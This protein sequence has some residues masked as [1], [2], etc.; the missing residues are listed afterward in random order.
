LAGAKVRDPFEGE[1]LV[2]KVDQDGAA[3]N[4]IKAAEFLRSG[5]VD[6]HRDPLDLGAQCLLGDREPYAPWLRA[7]FRGSAAWRVV[8]LSLIVQV[9]GDNL[10]PALLHLEGPETVPGPH[11]E[12]AHPGHVRRKAV[13]IDVRT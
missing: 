4:Q 7:E 9:Q 3:E 12:R 1:E 13:A 6:A 2:A 8:Q 11:L 5:V 10:G